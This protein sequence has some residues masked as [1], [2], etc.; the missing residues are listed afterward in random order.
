MASE[1]RVAI[2]TGASSGFGQLASVE[3]ARRGYTVVATMRD[4]EGRGR[5]LFEAAAREGVER[6]IVPSRLDVTDASRSEA[7]V[8]ETIASY[9]RI[10]VLVNNAGFAQGGFVEDVSLEAMRAQFETNVWGTIAM[11]KAA[12]PH[13]RERRGGKIVNMSSVSGRIAI[14]GFAPYAAS[15]YAI[16]G[17][18]EA[19]R[20][21]MRP[22]GVFVV[23][24]EP[25]S[26]R[27][28]IWDK[29][30][31]TMAGGADSAFAKPLARIRGI[32]E[33]SARNG[34]DPRDVARLIGRIA[35]ARRPRLRYA[36][37]RGAG[38]MAAARDLLP[39]SWYE[40]AIGRLLR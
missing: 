22:F 6:R 28:D 4:P 17:F 19:L 11:T 36:I 1:T 18:S 9:G 25:A 26:Y 38:W 21:E 10:D 20:L 34:G 8:A 27:T 35:D 2:V 30:F 7:V 15:K 29:G 13:M 39:W 40:A 23:L 24:I 14:P 3:L 33:R 32:A 5:R 12:L 16:E 31:A 37:P